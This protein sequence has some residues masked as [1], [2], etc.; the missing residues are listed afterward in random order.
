MSDRVEPA[1][2]ANRGHENAAMGNPAGLA[3]LNQDG[4]F[5]AVNDRFCEL[6]GLTRKEILSGSVFTILN[7]TGETSLRTGHRLRDFCSEIRYQR[8]D[9]QITWLKIT[10]SSIAAGGA[11]AGA[12]FI[13]VVEE[14]SFRKKSEEALRTSERKLALH[15][16]QTLF[17]VIE[18]TPDGRVN[19]W[20]PAAEQIF[21]YS[22][23]EAL[24]RFPEELIVP[25]EMTRD[26]RRVFTKLREHSGGQY[27]TNA[28]VTKEGKRIVCEWFNTPLTGENGEGLG[29]ISL[30]QDVTERESAEETLQREKTFTDAVIDSLPGLFYLYDE[31]GRLLRWNRKAEE[32][33]GYTPRELLNSKF[34]M[35]H[36]SPE[37]VQAIET[38]MRTVLSEGYAE[39]EANLTT[40]SGK[41]RPFYFTGVRLTLDGQRYI[42]GVGID[43]TERKRAEE[44]F[45]ENEERLKSLFDNAVLGLYRTTPD[46]DILIANPALCRMLG[47][48]SLAE[49]QQRNLEQDGFHPAYPRDQYKRELEE[50]LEPLSGWK[51]PGRGLTVGRFLCERVLAPFVTKPGRLSFTKAPSR[52]SRSESVRRKHYARANNGFVPCT[53]MQLLASSSWPQMAAS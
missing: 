30:V 11:G 18:W 35:F 36:G 49:L 53:R 39:I 27:S 31:S 12:L 10:V 47:Y 45:R 37:N 14:V 13:G 9:K 4:A 19:E 7:L 1:L 24:G 15:L 38:A 32:V 17:G 28:N 16:K 25:Q 29:V 42:T 43:L 51:Q 48:A 46:G 2:S 8:P 33:T 5:V 20:N 6:L 40:K 26:V 52:T 50:K 3:Q 44:A 23:S 21:G 22:R 41:D 34:S